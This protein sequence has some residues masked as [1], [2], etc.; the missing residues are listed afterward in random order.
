VFTAGLWTSRGVT[1]RTSLDAWGETVL[2][3]ATLASWI[4]WATLLVGHVLF[5]SL[6]YQVDPTGLI[7]AAFLLTTRWIRRESVRW[8]VVS[9]TLFSTAVLMPEHFSVS[10][11]M[12]AVVLLLCAL[13]Q[14]YYLQD[15]TAS[16]TD[17]ASPY[18]TAELDREPPQSS[19]IVTFARADGKTMVRFLWGAVFGLYLSIWT[20]GWPG[21]PW[22]EHSLLL[23]L[24]LSVIVILF[25]WKARTRLILGP[26]TA[27]YLHLLIQRE[28]ITSPSSTLE[29]GAT[30][31][32]CGFCLL[33]LSVM[34]S[35]WIRRLEETD[36][37]GEPYVHSGADND[38][39]REVLPRTQPTREIALPGFRNP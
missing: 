8:C 28:L 5:W 27:T 32:G 10:C 13:R 12:A 3:R 16:S 31:V 19:P 36:D 23:D 4:I 38:A 7:P 37:E 1:S 18:R 35:W 29:W 11:A 24:L 22:P 9:A 17:V 30:S 6:E 39:V 14:P 15:Q 34:V 2:R 25:A 21:G 33:F 20:C 26:L